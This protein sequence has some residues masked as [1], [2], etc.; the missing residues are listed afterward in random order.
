MREIATDMAEGM[1]MISENYNTILNSVL[2][3]I[4]SVF[5]PM[6]GVKMGCHFNNSMFFII[7]YN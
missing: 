7:K 5:V 2:T 1:N 3:L 4:N 6:V